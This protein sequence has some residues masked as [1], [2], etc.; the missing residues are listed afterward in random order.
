MVKRPRRS[1]TFEYHW[2]THHKLWQKHKHKLWQK[3]KP[4]DCRLN[5]TNRNNNNNNANQKRGN[6]RPNKESAEANEANDNADNSNNNR[7][8]TFAPSSNIAV[9]HADDDF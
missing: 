4:A 2:C 3:H 9:S 8:V 7:R 5:P 6:K 1:K